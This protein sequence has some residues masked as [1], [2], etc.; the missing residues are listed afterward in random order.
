MEFEYKCVAAPEK[1][2][3]R[4]GAKTRTDRVALAMQDILAAEAVGGWEYQRTDLIPVEEKSG[5]FSRAHEVHRA[6]MVFRRPAA[7]SAPRPAV[8][9]SPVSAPA[10]QPHVEQPV[11]APV[12]PVTVEPETAPAPAPVREAPV[13][14]ETD[15]DFRLAAEPPQTPQRAGLRA[16]PPLT[17]KGLG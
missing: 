5:M 3:R 16:D 1:A 11:P 2:R 17:P 8:Q 13:H 15:E 14:S 4:R 12:A 6:V 7:S 10:P 9:A